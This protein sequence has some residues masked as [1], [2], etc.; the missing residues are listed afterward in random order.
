MNASSRLNDLQNTGLTCPA[1]APPRNPNAVHLLSSLH[2][3]VPSS[4]ANDARLLDPDGRLD[5]LRR[6]SWYRAAMS[7]GAGIKGCGQLRIVL[8]IFSARRFPQ[9]QDPAGVQDW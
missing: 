2:V 3:Q 9:A 8:G 4:Q 1:P 6:S 7:R 5:C